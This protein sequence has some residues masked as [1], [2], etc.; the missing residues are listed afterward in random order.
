MQPRATKVKPTLVCAYRRSPM[1]ETRQNLLHRVVTS[2]AEAG[3]AERAQA[4][5]G[6]GSRGVSQMKAR[7]L[8]DSAS[9]GPDAL[10]SIGGNFSEAQR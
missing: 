7:A 8:I 6:H 5:S 9:L 1:R 4:L 3:S 2:R 10:A